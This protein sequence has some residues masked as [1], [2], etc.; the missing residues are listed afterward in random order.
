MKINQPITQNEVHFS[1]EDHLV[2]TTDLKGIITGVSPAFVKLSGFAEHELVGQSHNVVRHPEMPRQAFRSLWE[3][4]KAG[5]SWNGRVK[6][7][8]KNGDYYWVDAHVAPIFDEGKIIGYRSIRFKP[9]REQVEEAAKLYADL[10]VG[11]IA[12][13]FQTGLWA[14]LSANVKL[15]QKFLALVVLTVVMFAL[16]SGLLLQRF[17]TE[18]AVSVA[19]EQGAEYVRESIKLLRL[20]QLHRGLASMALS[21][22][23][24]SAENWHRVR[25]DINSQIGVVGEADRRFAHFGLRGEWQALTGDWSSLAFDADRLDVQTSIARHSA[26]IDGLFKFNRKLSDVSGMALDPEVNTYYM[27]LT[28]ITHLPEMTEA[29]G[30]LRAVGSGILVRQTVTAEE[31]TV[32]RQLLESVTK[33]QALVEENTGKIPG[34]DADS[35]NLLNKMHKDM[36]RIAELTKTNIVE[37]GKP[38]FDNRVFFDT[39][40]AAIDLRYQASGRFNQLLLTALDQRINR[41]Q[42]Q[43]NSLVATIS[44]LFVLFI[45]LSG[46]TVRGVLIPVKAINEALDQ[47]RHGKMPRRNAHDYGLEF[48]QV[49][50]GLFSAVLSVQALIADAGILSQAAVQGKLSA[51]ADARK[52][53]GDFRKIVEGVNGTL[54]AVMGPLNV[55]A[56]YVDKIAKGHIPAKIVDAYQG[57]FN[58]IKNNLNTCIDAIHALIEDAGMLAAAA[59]AGE[60]KTRADA[61]R[62]QGDYR[63][64]VEGVNATLDAVIGPLTQMQDVLSA[65]EKGDMTQTIATRYRGQ[66]ED[67]RLAVNNTVQKLSETINEV[68]VAAD[69]LGNAS[70]QVNATSQSLAQAA[71]SQANSVDKTSTSIESMAASI[72]RNA[73]NA[74]VTDGMAGKAVQEANEGGV[75]VGQTVRAMKNIAE[76][77]GI[78]DDIA[79]QTN[80]LALNAAIEA[81]RAGDHGKGFAVVAAEVRKLAER[82]QIAAQEIGEL[83]S[84][85][86]ATAETAGHLLEAIVP[87]IT[88]TSRLVQ[89]IAETSQQQTVGVSDVNSVMLQLGN[90]TQ[91]NASASE[92]LAA[93]AEELTSQAEALQDLMS[94]FKIGGSASNADAHP[95]KGERT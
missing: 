56:D 9:T 50:E 63:K 61:N 89:E 67:L 15:W 26:L 23:S 2:S 6:N 62:H 66:L 31:A 59:V 18:I 5:R 71:S 22:D 24:R 35:K 33:N 32:L 86:V 55:A 58:I 12:D 38:N 43:R 93:T 7:R 21:G 30:K 47:L 20:L 19:E 92:Q 4:V 64:I 82:S 36:E 91:Q 74:E 8:C 41:L 54:D 42:G 79:Y 87:S 81:A 17:N 40:S 77:I 10:N 46:F 14:K 34:L 85:S 70:K 68:I 51:R 29:L 16:P 44:V 11:R 1:E 69:Q 37:A 25:E 28:A 76:K 84:A 13:P 3:T 52:H 75:A 72:D 57:D 27:M 95:Y 48:N 83:A 39:L 73:K 80:M 60:L 53:Q 88:E 49:Q 65:I 90:I 78:I 45:G 94:F